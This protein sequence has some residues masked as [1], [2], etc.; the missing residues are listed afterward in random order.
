M[1]VS[2]PASHFSQ[3]VLPMVEKI[4]KVCMR[5]RLCF[6]IKFIL[7]V[8]SQFCYPQCFVQGLKETDGLT[9]PL[10]A[11]II[12]QGDAVGQWKGDK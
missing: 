1:M 12:D 4:M 2:E 7:R 5:T 6:R 11:A 10:S 9:G 3:A 8:N